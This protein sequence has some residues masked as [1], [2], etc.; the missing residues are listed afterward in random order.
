[1][2][3][4]THRTAVAVVPP[5]ELWGSIQETRRR[6]D[7]HIGRWMPHVN[8]LYPFRPRVDF[9]ATEP[10]LA[11]ACQGLEP[12]ALTLAA[13]RFFRHPSGRCTLWLAPE[14]AE[15]L[16][17]LQAALQSACPDCDELSRFPAAFTPH[18]SVGQF[19]SSGECG[20]V[21]EQL[22][23][24]WRPVTFR[25]AEVALLV[26]DS[27]GPFRIAQRIPLGGAAVFEPFSGD[28]RAGSPQDM[29]EGRM[30]S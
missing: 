29:E 15:E 19:P 5:E 26:R 27:D 12:F 6:H 28:N 22:Q 18:L 24:R 7:R 3:G 10:A 1:M 23:A 20:R 30:T 14:P 13:L 9:P 4:K 17:R 8:L 21:Q 25:L 11:A 16:V 2:P